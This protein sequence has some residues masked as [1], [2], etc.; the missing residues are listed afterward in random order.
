MQ[1][2]AK[3][4]AEV[5]ARGGEPA[6]LRE[7]RLKALNVYEG[8]PQPDSSRDEDWRRT[9]ARH[10]CYEAFQAA[11]GGRA[12]TAYAK[13]PAPARGLLGDGHSDAPLLV[14]HNA[15][16]AFR[17]LSPEL[18]R[19]GVIVESL[20]EAVR[21]HADLV[22]DYLGRAVPLD[23]TRFSALNS[24]GWEG[25]SFIYVPANVA[26]ADT[27]QTMAWHDQAG[28][29]SMPRSLIVLDKGS[30]L[31]VVEQFASPDQVAIITSAVSEIYVKS[32]AHLTYISV[33]R[34]GEQTTHFEARRA[35]MEQGAT[36]EFI[37]VALGSKVCKSYIDLVLNG[38]GGNADIRGVLFPT[39]EQHLD[40]QTLQDHEAPHT[41]STLYLKAALKGSAR[42][43]FNGLIRVPR[44]AQ[45][46][47]SFMEMRNL[48]LDKKAKADAIPGLEIEA[49]D[50]RC[51]HAV[52]V[53]KVEEQEVFYL[54]TR[55][56]DRVAAE[57][58]LVNG[59]FQPVMEKIPVK[60]VRQQIE[61]VIAER[62]AE[63]R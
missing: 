47:N 61:Q 7:Q 51:S 45:Q 44:V 20:S 59:F 32:G 62:T 48:L 14:Q 39:G 3:L 49:N 13:L 23:Y 1:F 60:A 4:V 30:S 19:Q 58:M 28:T 52:A 25:G 17:R 15:Q 12:V 54:Q 24:L 55:G 31:T 63:S 18:E 33:Q 57:R 41:E 2:D 40:H 27:L 10:F 9:D 43:V 6:W 22:R 34:W 53:G 38:P 5:A 36:V 11:T 16:P 42:S 8:L 46:S 56:M 37:P 29:V 50:V 21:R 35:L 26:V